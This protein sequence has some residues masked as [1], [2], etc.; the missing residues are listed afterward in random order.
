V[1]NSQTEKK[2]SKFLG[3]F[4]LS[5]GLLGVFVATAVFVTHILTQESI[6]A[7]AAQIPVMEQNTGQNVEQMQAEIS[8]L[9]ALI[10]AL[11]QNMNGNGQGNAPLQAGIPTISSQDARNLALQ[12]VGSGT[13][14][15]SL[16]FSENGVPMFEV[17]VTTGNIRYTV[18]INAETSHLVR[19]SRGEVP[20][21]VPPPAPA[22]P[23]PPPV[24]QV[25][26]PPVS[27]AA[28]PN[29]PA[30]NWSSPAWSSPS[31]WGSASPGGWGSA[32][33]GGRWSA[34]PRR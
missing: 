4:L 21:A 5:V 26:A 6:V 9:R 29:A 8:E 27:A 19:M 25:T 7:Q 10:Q 2:K 15:E 12:F 11:L 32:S 17:E 20:A 14:G 30:T 13:V 1:K 28:T 3:K 23:P 34:S 33:P 31:G 22:P 24:P 18:H 16:F